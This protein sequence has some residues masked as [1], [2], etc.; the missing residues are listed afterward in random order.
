MDG[1]C[2]CEIKRYLLL[3]TKAMTNL[4]S[5][6]KAEASLC[7]QRSV[8]SKRCFSISHVWMWEFDHKEGCVPKIWI[9]RI[10]VLQ[11]A[12]ESP[13]DSMEIKAVILNEIHTEYSLE[14]LMLRVKLQYFGHQMGITDPWVN[15]LMLVICW[16]QRRREQQRMRWLNSITDSM[17]V[18]L[19]KLWAYWRTRKPS[20]LQ[21]MGSQR[22]GHGLDTQQQQQ[23][24]INFIYIHLKCFLLPKITVY[25][26]ML[27]L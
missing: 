22:I 25:Q 7:Q 23:Q 6:L 26:M 1:D 10:A 13:V 20:M 12:L 3:G 14:E 17:D 8:W 9:F 16:R 15:T 27:S 2:S 19:S 4:N 24:Q 18:N 11:K 5:V 21:S